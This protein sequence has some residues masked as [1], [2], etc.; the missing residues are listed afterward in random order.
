M[1]L[2]MAGYVVRVSPHL[3][4]VKIIFTTTCTLSASRMTLAANNL[5]N[6]GEGQRPARPVL[7]DCSRYD[8]LLPSLNEITN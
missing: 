4:G 8:E 5:R 6:P 2:G 1:K 7:C 3:S